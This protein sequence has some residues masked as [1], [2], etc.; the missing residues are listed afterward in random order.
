MVKRCHGVHTCESGYKVSAFTTKYI[1]N[2]YVEE[3]RANEKMSLKGLA[4]LVQ[5]DWKMTPKRGK[6]VRARKHAFA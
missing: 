3:I 6:L 5:K 4:Q 1:G 2:Y